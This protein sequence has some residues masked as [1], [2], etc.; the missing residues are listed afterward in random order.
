MR[1]RKIKWGLVII[2][3]CLVI[4]TAIEIVFFVEWIT[5]TMAIKDMG[6]L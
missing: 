4:Q 2:M 5:T 3:I 6:L 1:Q